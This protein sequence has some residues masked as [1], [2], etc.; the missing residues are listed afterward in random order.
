LQSLLTLLIY[1]STE[2]QTTHM[3]L[4]LTTLV[5]NTPASYYSISLALQ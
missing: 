3:P 1:N 2:G 5:A 4:L